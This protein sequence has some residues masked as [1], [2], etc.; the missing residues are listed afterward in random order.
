[1]KHGRRRATLASYGP[2]ISQERTPQTRLLITDIAASAWAADSW[3]TPGVYRELPV[4]NWIESHPGLAAW[5]QAIGSLV[6]VGAAALIAVWQSASARAAERQAA[7]QTLRTNRQSVGLIVATV[8]RFVSSF[9]SNVGDRPHLDSLPHV[10]TIDSALEVYRDTI[11]ALR[12][13]ELQDSILC[14][15][16]LVVQSYIGGILDMLENL[17]AYLRRGGAAADEIAARVNFIASAGA[18]VTQASAEFQQRLA[19]LDPEMPR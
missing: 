15:R 16:V 6:A 5:V 8:S 3:K 11:S 18:S 12:M 14:E 13:S 4:I 7:Q 1:M 19:L 2:V 17:R 9:A 10:R